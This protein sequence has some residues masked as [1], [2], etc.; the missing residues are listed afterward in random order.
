MNLLRTES[1][2]AKCVYALRSDLLQGFLVSDEELHMDLQKFREMYAQ[3]GIVEYV[4]S[5]WVFYIVTDIRRRGRLNFYTSSRA[6]PRDQIFVYFSE[7]RNVGVKTM[8]K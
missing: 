2:A 3:N 7:E 4:S 8:R 5:I 1:A 6:N